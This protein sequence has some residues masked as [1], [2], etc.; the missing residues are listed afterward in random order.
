MPRNFGNYLPKAQRNIPKDYKLYIIN[1][2]QAS[3]TLS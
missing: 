2:K 3:R 1:Y